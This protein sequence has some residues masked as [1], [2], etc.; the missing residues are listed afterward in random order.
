MATE[1][2]AV[3]TE[4]ARGPATSAGPRGQTTA[5]P[6]RQVIRNPVSRSGPHPGP[7]RPDRGTGG[8]LCP[9]FGFRVIETGDAAPVA[10]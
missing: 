3:A 1:I 5:D 4:C 6:I 7:W 8:R 2:F 9:R 10:L